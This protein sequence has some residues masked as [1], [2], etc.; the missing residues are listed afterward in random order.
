[1]GNPLEQRTSETNNPKL[2]T[3]MA[4][5]PRQLITKGEPSGVMNTMN[6]GS[7]TP[8]GPSPSP[9]KK[10]DDG[11]DPPPPPGPPLTLPKKGN[12]GEDPKD[13]NDNPRDAPPVLQSLEGEGNQGKEMENPKDNP[14][15]EPEA[16][17]VS[18]EVN[19]F[20]EQS[21]LELAALSGDGT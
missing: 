9:T 16:S 6:S 15:K 1:M 19:D 13:V 17:P 14:I 3:K 20:L 21:N 18:K 12:D 8:Q 2:Q 5:N 10:E 7:E 11:Q 4:T